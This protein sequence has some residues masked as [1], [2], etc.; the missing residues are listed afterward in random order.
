MQITDA[1]MGAE[2]PHYCVC[3]CVCVRES[4]QECVRTY[5]ML[6]MCAT[7]CKLV[8]VERV[9]VTLLA[10]ALAVAFVSACKNVRLR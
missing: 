6:C 7:V 10:L 4:A 9:H 8:L 5:S 2:V 3:V 1:L